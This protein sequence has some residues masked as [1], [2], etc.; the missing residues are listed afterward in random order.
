MDCRVRLLLLLLLPLSVSAQTSVSRQGITGY[1]TRISSP[2]DFDVA[3]THVITDAQTTYGTQND[4]QTLSTPTP[5]PLYLGQT[6]DIF[7]KR[8]RKHH[9]VSAQFVIVHPQVASPVSGA[10]IVDLLVPTSAIPGER[11]LRA[12]GYL[13][14]IGSG[15]SLTYTP[16]LASTTPLSTNLWIRYHGIQ[17]TDGTVLLDHGELG[18]N[19]IKPAENKLRNVSEY[20]PAAVDPDAKQNFL[21]KS[22][23]G[24]DP[25][26]IPPYGKDAA[27]QTRIERIG[28]AL[29]P[30]FQ[31]N[32]PDSDPTKIHFRFQLIDKANWRD[33][34]A[35]SSGIILV[36]YQMIERVA[37]DSEVAAILADSIAV[38]LEKQTLRATPADHKMT[39]ARIAGAAGGIFVPGL[40]LATDLAAGSAGAHLLAQEQQQSGRVSLCLL[41]DAGYDLREAPL[42][43][44]LLA[45]TKPT[46]IAHV[47]LPARAANLYVVLGTTWRET[48]L[49]S[50]PAQPSVPEILP[51][52]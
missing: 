17:Q 18:A 44:W 15:T 19:E 34:F 50:G 21:S 46:D 39:A 37:N 51:T 49:S 14:R 32:L 7:G 26:L 5:L 16:P 38:A 33:A 20:D 23:F 3:G 4:K 12:D 35:L 2:T 28:K 8:D 11:I 13:L 48:L 1:V 45:P 9:T 27:M 42:A 25:Q 36:P 30:A 47:P 40:G 10:G 29:V 6:V 52:P 31:R 43:W 22:L 24:D 41:H